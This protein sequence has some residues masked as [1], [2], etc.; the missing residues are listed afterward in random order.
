MCSELAAAVYVDSLHELVLCRQKKWNRMKTKN[1]YLHGA[2]V[3]SVV[4]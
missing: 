2:L 4:G 1:D 3:G